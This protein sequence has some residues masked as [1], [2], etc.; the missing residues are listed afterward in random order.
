MERD[1]TVGVLFVCLGN[2]CRS[3]LAEAVFRH[4]AEREGVHERFRIDSAGTS[5]YHEGD[6]PDPRTI[7]V[8]R[9]RGVHVEHCARQV[10]SADFEEFDYVLAMDR[11]NLRRLQR[12]RDGNGGGAELRLLRSF[13]AEAER[14][15]EVPDPYFGGEGGFEAVHNLVERACEGLLA[16]VR[17]EYGF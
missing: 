16:H 4:L 14:H 10:R 12:V 15:A 3:P 1:R 11:E 8:A 9:S 2:I 7:Q 5:N 13:D 17:E 6:S